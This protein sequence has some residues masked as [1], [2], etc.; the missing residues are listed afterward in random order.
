MP[1]KSLRVWKC[2][3]SQVFF[4]TAVA[5][6]SQLTG[7]PSEKRRRQIITTSQWRGERAEA[8]EAGFGGLGVALAVV[9]SISTLFLLR[10]D[11][12]GSTIIG[13]NCARHLALLRLRKLGTA[14]QNKRYQETD[15]LRPVFD[16]DKQ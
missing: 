5:L 13:A 3:S 14:C 12:Y 2:E 4:A 16:S 1:G 11:L 15:G 10:S 6:P 8:H 7:A 9:V